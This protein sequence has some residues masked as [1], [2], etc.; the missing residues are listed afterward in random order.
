MPN[1]ISHPQNESKEVST[2]SL[3]SLILPPEFYDEF[4]SDLSK[5]RI[6]DPSWYIPDSHFVHLFSRR[7]LTPPIPQSVPSSRL[8]SARA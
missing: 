5:R 7:S 4:I 1:D 3:S 8:K 6:E 2:K